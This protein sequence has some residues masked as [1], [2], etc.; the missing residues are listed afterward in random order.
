MTSDT[1]VMNDRKTTSVPQAQAPFLGS[2]PCVFF[3]CLHQY[4]CENIWPSMKR[5]PGLDL[6]TFGVSENGLYSFSLWLNI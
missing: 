3:A 6:Q 4:M 5:G 1:W 2:L